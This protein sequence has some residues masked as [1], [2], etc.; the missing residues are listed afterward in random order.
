MSTKKRLCAVATFVSLFTLATGWEMGG[1]RAGGR[2]ALYASNQGAEESSTVQVIVRFAKIRNRPE[3]SALIVKE[4]GFGTMLRVLGRSG[5]YFQ[6]AALDASAAAPAEPWYVL[7]GEVDAVQPALEQALVEKRRVS[8]SPDNPAAGQPVLFKASRFRTPKL[9]KWD[10]GDGT[11]LTSGSQVSQDQDATILHMYAAPG[12]YLVKVFDDNGNMALPPVTTQVTVS[13]LARLLRFN[14]EQPLANHP[15][16]ITASNFKTPERIAWDLGDGTEIKPGA[17]PGVIKPSFLVSHVYEKAGTYT[18][19]AHDQGGD[20]SQPPLAVEIR[21][22]ADPRRIQ[23]TPARA[24]T[25]RSLEFSAVDFNT[26]ERLRWDMGDGTL[27]PSEKETGVL[28]GSLVNYGYKKP[29]NYL[30]KAYDWNGDMTRR[31]VQFI[32]TV[33]SPADAAAEAVKPMQPSAQR[34]PVEGIVAPAK[35]GKYALIKFSPFAGYFQPKDE[36]IRQIY[37]DGDLVYGA[38]LGIHVWEGFYFW[39]SASQFKVIGKTTITK[40][41]TTLTLLPV[42]ASLIYHAGRG[43]L[44]PYAGIGFNLLSYKEESEI[45]GSGKGHGGSVFFEGGLELRMNRHFSID[46]GA[47]IGQIKVQPENAPEKIDLGGLQATVAF[48]VSF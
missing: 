25:G 35:R 42:S 34:M 33:T 16:A 32:V 6:V 45:V 20:R 4:I 37:G 23:V 38:R 3:A 18:V 5:E 11:V 48:L 46:L 21:V 15:V 39:L 29:G 2:A 13:A 28:V 8:F 22:A 24:E 26:P 7:R 9:L 44:I 12:Q 10:M 30:V 47:R 41:K 14:P 43:F 27:I 17:G 1:W 40:D 31:P 36:F 19:K